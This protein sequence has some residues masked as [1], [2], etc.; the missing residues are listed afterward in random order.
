MNYLLAFIKNKTRFLFVVISFFML[1]ALSS[2]AQPHK[3]TVIAVSYKTSNSVSFAT[4]QQDILKYVNEYR[5]TKNLPPLQMNDA[6]NTEAFS[7]SVDMAKG[8]VP[9]GH[10]GFN[11]RMNYIKSKEGFIRGGAE[12]VAYGKVDAREVVNMW[13]ESPGHKQNIEGQFAFTGIGI[14]QSQDGYLYFTQVFF[15]K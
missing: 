3:A 9:F 4:M 1:S 15:L 7:H 10:D 11:D 6:A 12:N 2:C 8:T 5:Q 13:L 14:A